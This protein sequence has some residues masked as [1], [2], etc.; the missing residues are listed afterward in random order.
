MKRLLLP[1][2]VLGSI[3]TL[4]AAPVSYTVSVDSSSISHSTAGYIE[5]QFNQAN[6]NTSLA[7]TASVFNFSATG[8]TFDHSLDGSLGGVTGSFWA[9]PVQFD[10]TVGGSNYYDAGVTAFG[11]GFSFVVT[12]DGAAL[13]TS[14][15]DGS[16]FFVY[17]LGTDFSNLLGPD[18]TIAAAVTIN[19]DTTITTNPVSGRSTINSYTASETPEP[20]TVLLFGIG[21]A[22]VAIR[23]RRAA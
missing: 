4:A 21:G 11:T 22:M 8:F 15:T 23:R 13:G 10:N 20:S 16:E 18:G 9:P 3:A 2:L 1:F 19:G 14:S 17:L 7:A 6:A 12:L 5:I